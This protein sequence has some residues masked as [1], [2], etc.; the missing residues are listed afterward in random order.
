MLIHH[1]K[2]K[3]H[4]EVCKNTDV[5]LCLS[6]IYHTRTHTHT[7]VC[8][9]LCVL[10]LKNPC[11]LDL[12]WNNRSEFSKIKT[13]LVARNV[14]PLEGVKRSAVVQLPLLSSLQENSIEKHNQ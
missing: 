14:F 13:K 11:D 10:R 7:R 2:L 12:G 4:L 6:H 3:N 5:I 9:C 1:Y 8:L